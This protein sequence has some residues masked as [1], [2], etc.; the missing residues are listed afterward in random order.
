MTR[1]IALAAT[2]TADQIAAA[3]ADRAARLDTAVVTAPYGQT[4]EPLLDPT[5]VL[6]ANTGVNALLLRLEDLRGGLLDEL[7]AALAA[8]PGRSTATWLIAVTPPSPRALGDRATAAWLTTAARRV[9]D[10]V[11]ALPGVHL[12]PTDDLAAH[13]GVP[14]VHD[15]YADRIAHLPYTDEFSSALADRVVRLAA[16]TWRAPR[17][18]VV[19]DCDDTLWSGLCGE[20][21]PEGVEVG[22][23]HRRVQEF[24]QD[25]RSRG[26][27]LCLCSH[28][29]TEDVHAVFDR[30]PGMAL[31]L[32]EITAQRIGWAPKPAY[33]GELAAEL[34]LA[35]SSFIFV[36]DD[37]VACASVRA[38]LPEVAVVE[39][40]RDGGRAWRQLVHEPAFDQL[41][42]T[43]EDRLRSDWYAAESHRKELLQST[44]DYEEFLARCDIEVS[45]D[46]LTDLTLERAAQLTARTTQFTLTGSAWT[47]PELRAFLARSGTGWVVRVRD[48]FGDHGVVGLVLAEAR[49][50][51]LDVPVFLLSCRM[52]NRRVDGA[53]LRLLCAE[54]ISADC[55]EVRLH[56]ESTRRNAPARHFV[57]QLTGTAVGPADP[58]GSADVVAADWAAG[59]VPAP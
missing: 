9:A 51:V 44:K 48:V 52:L 3:A 23:G 28:N 22:D 25:Q 43:E 5:S 15:E 27:L 33:L 53:V 59:A 16:S 56:H 57:E 47:V 20:A 42:V 2:F 46:R 55:A 14:E 6:L 41:A 58:P 50:G 32:R 45:L 39:V 1:G 12:M 24:L 34:G 8:A 17:K 10:A 13:Y 37:P 40:D 30:H 36:D 18:V 11:A 26:K 21:G 35:L 49:D 29:N 19:L 54:A 38:Q 31:S 4:V 7:L